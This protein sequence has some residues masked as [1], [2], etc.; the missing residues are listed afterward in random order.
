LLEAARAGG[1]GLTR[2]AIERGLEH[3]EWPARLEVLTLEEGRRV[4]L[5]A[6]HNADGAQALAAYL[7]QWHPERPVLVISVMRDKD[8]DDILQ[9]L[10]PVTSDV[11]VTLAPSPR[12]TAV[13][14]LAQRVARIGAAAGHVRSITS[15]ADPAAA[16]EAAL[17]QADSVCVA[18]SIFLAGAV[19]DGLR[20][21]A[22]LH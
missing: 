13:G 14:E 18:G 9:A 1:V 21:R 15:I 8:I 2:A 20:R 7:R 10:L 5:D 6:A 17:A 16:V 3:A 19:R 22:I 12:A 4:V 11:I